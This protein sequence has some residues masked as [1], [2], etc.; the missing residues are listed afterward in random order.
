MPSTKVAEILTDAAAKSERMRE[1][2]QT[3]VQD[4]VLQRLDATKACQ[5]NP[6]QPN[7]VWVPSIFGSMLELDLREEVSASIFTYGVFDAPLLAFLSRRLKPGDVFM[8]VGAHIGFFTLAAASLV[9]DEGVV[10]AFEPSP[11]TFDRL[12]VNVRNFGRPNVTIVKA[13]AWSEPGAIALNDFGGAD[14]AFNSVAAIRR[15]N[16]DGQEVKAGS[17]VV[18]AIRLDDYISLHALYPNVIKIDVESAEFQVVAGLKATLTGDRPP[19]LV[20]EVGDFDH[21]IAA[22]VEPSASLLNLIQ[23]FGYDLFEIELDGGLSPHRVKVEA[24]SYMNVV[25]VPTERGD[26]RVQTTDEEDK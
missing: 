25:C 15:Q 23:T 21:L 6:Y 7:L 18:D 1:A 16:E 8:D 22:G 9:D 20:I 5:A 17:H 11:D 24:Y 14:S 19:V 12:T 10:H 26:D 13:A 3:L 2:V 4:G